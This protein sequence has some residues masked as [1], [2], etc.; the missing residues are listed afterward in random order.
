MA[1][2]SSA[3]E[4]SP[5]NVR[6]L[7]ASSISRSSWRSRRLRCFARYCTS[8]VC[9]VDSL[10]VR[11]AADMSG[12]ALA[13]STAGHGFAATLSVENGLAFGLSVVAGTSRLNVLQSFT[14]VA[15][16]SMV[17]SEA[18][19]ITWVAGARTVASSSAIS[20]IIARSLLISALMVD[21]PADD[22]ALPKSERVGGTSSTKIGRCSSASRSVTSSSVAGMSFSPCSSSSSCCSCCTQSEGG[23]SHERML[24][25]S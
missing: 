10:S 19:W 20:R 24:V 4:L 1:A 7:R 12:C 21:Q 18:V 15:D 5:I 22:C 17:S 25:S 3:R 9:P 6:S 16:A 13:A 8:V 2:G 23:G 11:L 14:G